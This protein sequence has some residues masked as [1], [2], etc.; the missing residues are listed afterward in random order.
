M[1][2]EAAVG[3]LEAV[4]LPALGA[5]GKGAQR[6]DGDAGGVERDGDR[7]TSWVKN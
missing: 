7:I 1:A 6:G 3:D 4:D 5:A 2:L